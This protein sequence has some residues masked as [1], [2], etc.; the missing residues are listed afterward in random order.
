MKRPLGLLLVMG[1]VG[2]WYPVTK[3]KDLGAKVRQGDDGEVIS[4]SLHRTWHP[5]TDVE[6]LHLKT[7]VHLKDLNLIDTQ[8][9]DVG[10]AYIRPL[11][12][13]QNLYLSGTRI[14]DAGLVHLKGITTLKQLHL[15]ACPKVTD[16]GLVHLKEL[17]ELTSLGLS[18]TQVTDAGIAELQKALPNCKIT[19]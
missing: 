1:I 19:K 17:T 5:I 8:I 16:A 11:T 9:T 14:T 3:L 7:L 10:V 2:C 12:R 18:G 6:I 4:V 13:L 15:S